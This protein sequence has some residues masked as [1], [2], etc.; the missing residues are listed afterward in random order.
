MT[1]RAIARLSG[2]FVVLF[3][4]LAIRQTW[5]SFVAGPVIASKANNPRHALLD[6][7]R[8]RI[9]ASDGTVLAATSGKKRIYPLGESLAQTVGYV[10]SRYGT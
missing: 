7:R 1:N 3:L 6:A 8:G 9:L 4:V 10:S 2:L 5:V